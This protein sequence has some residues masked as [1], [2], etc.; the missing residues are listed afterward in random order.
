MNKIMFLLALAV[1]VFGC[2]SKT[3]LKIDTSQVEVSHEYYT[4]SMHPQVHEKHTGQCPI[5]GMPLIKVS[6]NKNK[7]NEK[8][9]LPSDYQKEV[10]GFTEAV[11]KVQEV[12]FSSSVSGRLINSKL[13]AFYVYESEIFHM[14][15]GQSFEVEC[16][17][18]PGE[19]LKGKITQIDTIADPSSR[20]VR[21]IGTISSVHNFTLAEG[22][23]HGKILSAPE[24][25][26][27]IPYDSVLRTGKSKIVYI[28]QKNGEL[29]AKEIS[30]N[31]VHG[32][33]IEV[34]KG[35]SEGDVIAAGPNF[36]IDSESRLKGIEGSND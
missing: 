11:A 35:L 8:K 28:V 20:A 27:M 5:C 36:L 32:D 31:R 1:L 15:S 25:V 9:L 22:S 10:M 3:D 34:I 12:K 7:S 4:C 33:S 13:I 19:L 29:K 24:K 23:V 18:M 14:K 2:Q 30:V 16:S 26:L 21:V 17:A 6:S